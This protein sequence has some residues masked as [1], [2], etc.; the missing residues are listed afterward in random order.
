MKYFIFLVFNHYY[1]DGNYKNQD[2]PY[3]TAILM[4]MFY[5]IAI[6]IIV[7]SLI[8][9]LINIPVILSLYNLKRAS[10]FVIFLALYPLNYWYFIKKGEF[11]RIYN[12]Y[13]HAQINTKKNRIISTIFLVVIL[14]GLI[15]LIGHLKWLLT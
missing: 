4:L 3:F 10:G 6:L 13:R 15:V 9:W 5:E 7:L 14:L 8:E 2:M 12:N 11:E 1:K